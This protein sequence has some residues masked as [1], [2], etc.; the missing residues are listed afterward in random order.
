MTADYEA[1][2]DAIVAASGSKLV[3]GYAASECNTAQQILPAA[4]SKGFQV[5]LGV[6]PDVEASFTADTQA[7]QTYMPGYEAQVYAITVGSETLYRGTFTGPQLLAKINQVKQMFP[8]VLIG[9]ADSW[10]KYADGT[11]DAVISGGVDLLLANAFSYWQAT[12]IANATWNFFEDIFGAM[13]HIEDVLG[14]GNMGNVQFWVGETG[15]PTDGGSN[16]GA[17]TASTENA[18]TFFSQGVCSILRWNVNT[19]YFEAFDESWKPASIGDDGQAEVETVW[20]AMTAQRET[21]Y[22][23]KC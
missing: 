4:K 17:A 16:Y 11:A 8:G 3:R 1:D 9:T 18:A 5:V 7:I 15:W 22:S 2:F 12:P 20:G 10:N 21:K 19:F 13:L 14:K 6:W 23:L